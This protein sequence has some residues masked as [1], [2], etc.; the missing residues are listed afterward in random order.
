[1]TRIG[2]LLR[3]TLYSGIFVLAFGFATTMLRA[4]PTLYYSP[5]DTGTDPATVPILPLGSTETI[6]L[7][8]NPGTSRSTLGTVCNGGTGGTG[9]D[10]DES[11]A[12]HFKIAVTGDLSI[13]SFSPLVGIPEHSIN[14]SGTELNVTL[15]TVDPYIDVPLFPLPP[16]TKLGSFEL[17]VSG[18]DGGI[19]SVTLLQSVDADLDLVAGANRDVFYVPEPVLLVQLAF[20]ALGLAGL[21]L[22]RRPPRK[23]R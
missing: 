22:Q 14:I 4:A 13:L 2:S 3:I 9:G 10:G 19:G 1:M 6:H 8:F 17:D 16:W 11:C 5:D 15:V 20:G 23:F 18:I 7:Y 21:G 12:I